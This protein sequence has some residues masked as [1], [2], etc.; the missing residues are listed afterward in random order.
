MRLV[1]LGVGLLEP[2]VEMPQQILELVVVVAL[3]LVVVETVVLDLFVFVGE[4]KFFYLTFQ[5]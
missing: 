5:Q 3:A 2:L 1:V 4:F